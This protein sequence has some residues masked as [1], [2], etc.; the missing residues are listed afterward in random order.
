MRIKSFLTQMQ[1]SSQLVTQTVQLR[2]FQLTI[3]AYQSTCSIA[4]RIGFEMTTYSGAEVEEVIN[5]VVAVL[6]GTL[7]QDVTVRIYTM[8]ST[9]RCKLSFD[10]SQ[11]IFTELVIFNS[12]ST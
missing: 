12:F 1:Q 3:D 11:V 10:K 2:I 8:D 5:V 9:A 6:G 7:S 4:A